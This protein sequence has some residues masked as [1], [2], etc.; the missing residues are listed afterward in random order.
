M[1]Q[2]SQAAVAA[3]LCSLMSQINKGVLFFSFQMRVVDLSV[4]HGGNEK[5]LLNS[6]AKAY[7]SVLELNAFLTAYLDFEDIYF[8]SLHKTQVNPN[9][10]HVF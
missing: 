6:C 4:L 2:N 5:G 9:D 1:P 8:F 3:A 10:K 7:H